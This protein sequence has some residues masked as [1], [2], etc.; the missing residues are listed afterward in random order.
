MSPYSPTASLSART[1]GRVFSG[2]S[3]T[4]GCMASRLQQFSTPVFGMF[5]LF[6]LRKLSCQQ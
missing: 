1:A 2:C 6:Y 4:Y 5:S 3:A